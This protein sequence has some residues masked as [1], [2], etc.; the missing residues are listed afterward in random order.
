[1]IECS[2]KIKYVLLQ[3]FYNKGSLTFNIIKF[4]IFIQW[5]VF[6]CFFYF[7]IPFNLRNCL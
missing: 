7:F 1:M 5:V 2:I 6:I 3:N 4:F